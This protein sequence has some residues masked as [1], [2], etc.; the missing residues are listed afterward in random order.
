MSPKNSPFVELM[1]EY[2]LVVTCFS[3][4]NLALLLSTTTTTTTKTM[5]MK[6]LFVGESLSQLSEMWLWKLLLLSLEW[7]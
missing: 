7:K 5:K 2:W 3:M 4:T 6:L 1:D